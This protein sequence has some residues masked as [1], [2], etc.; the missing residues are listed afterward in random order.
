VWQGGG[1]YAWNTVGTVLSNL[2]LEGNN[3]STAGTLVANDLEIV[4]SPG[5][6][7]AFFVA[8]QGPVEATDITV[9]DAQGI[10]LYLSAHQPLTCTR[11]VTTD[12]QGMG[13][14]AQVPTDSQLTMIDGRIEG[15]L[16][17]GSRN[18]GAF[19]IYD[20]GPALLDGTDIVG[21]TGIAG[22]LYVQDGSTVSLVDLDLHANSA[23]AT[24][25]GVFIVDGT[26]ELLDVDFGVG[27]TEN[28]P[29]DVDGDSFSGPIGYFVGPTTA[30]CTESG[31]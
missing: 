18:A 9:R 10:G 7:G 6:Y 31:C 2:R 28:S 20:G 24:G 5:G 30:T 8:S 22:G 25:G 12:A 23:T 21:N 3:L 14:W 11:C 19:E 17:V 29:D 16:G 26:V 1:L 4:D 13:V 15:S 27:A